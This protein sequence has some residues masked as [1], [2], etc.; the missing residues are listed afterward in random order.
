MIKCKHPDCE[1]KCT[2]GFCSKE[3]KNHYK[4]LDKRQ[5]NKARAVE[6]LGGR[7]KRCGFN[8]NMNIFHFH[9]LDPADKKYNISEKLNKGFEFI[10]SE[11]NKCILLCI[12]C[13]LIVHRTNDPNYFLINNYFF[14]YD[15]EK[16]ERNLGIDNN[17]ECTKLESEKGVILQ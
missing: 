17:D 1:E 13:H 8:E 6:Y 14:G 7:C 16:L 9:H 10:R 15:F 5:N 3:C 4:M 12:N 2:Y 11:L